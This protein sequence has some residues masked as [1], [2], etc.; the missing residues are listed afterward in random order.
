MDSLATWTKDFY[1]TPTNE[2][3][4]K[5]AIEHSIR[6]WEGLY[7]HVL[8]AY[9]I[10]SRNG[11]LK[12]SSEYSPERFYIDYDSCALCTRYYITIDK[13]VDCP[14]SIV[15]GGV[16]CYSS[17]KDEILSPYHD[18]VFN[19]NNIPML[20]WLYAT[21]DYVTKIGKK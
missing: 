21:R 6:K 2:V 13:C 18:Y 14:L 16:P 9:G 1:P 7:E 19:N 3:S 20:E 11:V 4:K 15:R 10:V 8:D 17:R 5:D 12:D